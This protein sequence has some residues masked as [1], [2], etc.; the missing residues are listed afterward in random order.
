[1]KVISFNAGGC[2]KA[3]NVDKFERFLESHKDADIILIQ[4]YTFKNTDI[5]TKFGFY[6]DTQDGPLRVASKCGWICS[7]IFDENYVQAYECR[8]LGMRYDTIVVNVHIPTTMS[9]NK[10]Q[11]EG[12]D[13]LDMCLDYL[14]NRDEP[15]VVGGDFNIICNANECNPPQYENYY[16][17][18]LFTKSTHDLNCIL[19]EYRL[20]DSY[21]GTKFSTK[22]GNDEYLKLYGGGARLDKIFTKNVKHYH[23]DIDINDYGSQH[24]P[25][26]LKCRCK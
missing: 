3:D 18:P 22:G 5:F 4:E 23:C 26:I 10:S 6:V 16:S 13:N 24:R 11:T 17:R 12:L 21:K 1:M 2:A 19:S 9:A 7:M 25:V 14:M 15:I 8:A 20:K